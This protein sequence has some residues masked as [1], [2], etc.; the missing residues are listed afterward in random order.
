MLKPVVQ[1]LVASR[2]SEGRKITENK[3]QVTRNLCMSNILK[4]QFAFL[5]KC[6][7]LENSWLCVEKHVTQYM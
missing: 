3:Q 6:N 7:F 2:I 4:F 1:N 5:G